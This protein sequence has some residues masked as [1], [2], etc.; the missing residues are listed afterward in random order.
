SKGFGDIS[1]ALLGGTGWYGEA[2]LTAPDVQ[3]G[4]E[5]EFALNSWFGVG[6][7]AMTSLPVRG[8]QV[9]LAVCFRPEG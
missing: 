7:G 5:V 4:F 3:V 6:I 2:V 8:N 1:F 9:F